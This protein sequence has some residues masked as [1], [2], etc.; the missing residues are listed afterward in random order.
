MF[1]SFS[2]CTY[3]RFLDSA[4]AFCWAET[5][6]ISKSPSALARCVADVQVPTSPE[7]YHYTSAS[8][9]RLLQRGVHFHIRWPAV[10]VSLQLLPLFLSSGVPLLS[11][12]HEV[13]RHQQCASPS[14]CSYTP[15]DTCP[16][17]STTMFPGEPGRPGS[18]RN[19]QSQSATETDP[20]NSPDLLRSCCKPFHLAKPVSCSCQPH[21][22]INRH[23]H[24]C[25][26]SHR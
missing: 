17:T 10:F 5:P 16:A 20:C 19:N 4:L 7:S 18:R 23:R 22:A 3:R 9:K 11:S 25:S 26:N 12:D 13:C 1:I 6:A 24:Y 21:L 2:R 8:G 14:V 15:A